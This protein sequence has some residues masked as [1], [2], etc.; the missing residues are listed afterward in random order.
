MAKRGHESTIASA[1]A[2]AN[3]PGGG[4]SIWDAVVYAADSSK[5]PPEAS[6]TL[7]ICLLTDGEDNCSRN[8]VATATQQIQ[9]MTRDKTLKGLITITAGSG[10]SEGTKQKL[11]TL[12]Q[13]SQSVCRLKLG[14]TKS[15]SA[16][17]LDRQQRLWKTSWC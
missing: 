9:S 12:A 8:S 7:W 15:P 13:A 17:R 10:V 2:S 6:N 16:R 1:I 3:H 4:T 14:P 11:R 5:T